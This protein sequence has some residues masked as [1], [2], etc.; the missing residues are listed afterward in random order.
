MLKMELSFKECRIR[1]D[2]WQLFNS[3]YAHFIGSA[4]SLQPTPCS[5]RFRGIHEF[6]QRF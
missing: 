6:S 3:Q 2:G 5:N 1:V 4:S